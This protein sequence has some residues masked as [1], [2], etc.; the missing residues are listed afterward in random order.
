MIAIVRPD[1]SVDAPPV[2][3]FAFSTDDAPVPVL[4]AFAGRVAVDSVI[5]EMVR[6]DKHVFCTS[7][8]TLSLEFEFNGCRKIKISSFIKWRLF[9]FVRILT[10]S[11]I[12][13]IGSSR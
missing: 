4:A 12:I 2:V 7:L 3:I 8:I 11:I 10:D 5:R 9:S 13:C 1:W 6:R